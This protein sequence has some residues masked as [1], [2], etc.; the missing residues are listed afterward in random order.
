[1]FLWGVG[2]FCMFCM[3]QVNQPVPKRRDSVSR[4]QDKGFL[5]NS[6]ATVCTSSAFSHYS[7]FPSVSLPTD[8][9]FDRY[10]LVV[11]VVI[12][13]QRGQGVK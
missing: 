13:E 1:M 12:G 5:R 2:M 7:A 8:A 6:N 9:G 3:S 11:Q 4:T 10:K